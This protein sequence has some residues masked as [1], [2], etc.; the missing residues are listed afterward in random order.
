VIGNISF[1]EIDVK[2]SG[3][4]ML[5]VMVVNAPEVG[6]NVGHLFFDSFRISKTRQ[7]K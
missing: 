4:D 2:A 5:F 3:L 7:H 6:T 1:F